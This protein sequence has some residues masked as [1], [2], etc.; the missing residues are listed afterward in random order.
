[1]TGVLFVAYLAEAHRGG[2]VNL[3]R[4]LRG[5]PRERFAPLLVTPAPGTLADAARDDGVPVEVVRVATPGGRRRLRRLAERLRPDVV[6]VDGVADV[7][8][9]A[10]AA[11]AASARLVWHAQVAQADAA[12]RIAC[13]LADLV[14][15]CSRAVEERVAR[16]AP[17]ARVRRIVN[18]VDAARFRPA[19]GPRTGSP[20]LFYAG[21]VERDK[22]VGDLLAAFALV[23]EARRDVRLKVAGV[24]PPDEARLLE[25]EAL[26]LGVGDAVDWLGQRGDVADLLRDATVFVF[27][28]RSE[29]MSLALLEAA[30]SGCAI[31][32]SDIAGNRDALRAGAALAV[33]PADPA[34]AAAA[35]V[36][37]LVS[38]GERARLGARA[39]EAMLCGHTVEQ[40]VASF[41]AVFEQARHPAG[42]R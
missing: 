23:R 22:G 25:R 41:G 4:L 30:A 15:C 2:Q 29:G 32:M 18:A 34:A 21:A 20:V 36:R 37:L 31:V 13:E 11:R 17:P 42:A 28:S 19:A 9:A 12:D 33:A 35:I 40:F 38:P 6:Y 10:P 14:V 16:F 7:L 39:R 1:M 3:L 5:L 26:R 24:G 8:R 27:L